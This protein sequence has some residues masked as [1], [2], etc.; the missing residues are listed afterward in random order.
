MPPLTLELPL[1][2]DMDRCWTFGGGGKGNADDIEPDGGRLYGNDEDG[3]VLGYAA[4]FCLYWYWFWKRRD[5]AVH[6]A[7]AAAAAG[8]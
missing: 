3:I 5:C 2:A 1:P 8:Q 7:T 4:S 6:T